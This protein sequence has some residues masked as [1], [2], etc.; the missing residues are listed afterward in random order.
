MIYPH[1][2]VYISAD[3]FQSSSV[4]AY[5]CNP[6]M[7]SNPNKH[8]T[9]IPQYLAMMT[10]IPASDHLSS[11]GS[12][13]AWIPYCIIFKGQHSDATGRHRPPQPARPSG[14]EHPWQHG[15]L[16]ASS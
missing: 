8:T 9:A 16:I 11:H 6:P 1:V 12:M 15:S 2:S 10:S 3:L 14:P 7:S 5:S 4:L 13:A